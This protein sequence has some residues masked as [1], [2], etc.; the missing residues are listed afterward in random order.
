MTKP[1]PV[2]YR[3]TH[4]KSYNEALR[5]RGSLLIWLDK[6]MVWLAIR[7]GRRGR[8]PAFS[9]AAIQFCLMVKVL[10]GLPLRQTTGMIASILEMA[11][12]DWPVPDFSTLSRRQR[13]LAVQIPYRRG[14]GPLNL[15]V[16]ST[17]IKFL[18]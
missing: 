11:G 16:D 18:G 4:W 7:A 17:G 2:R 8:P 5:R 1:E 12:P 10:F 6:D 3:T 9:D 14:P 13:T 15:L